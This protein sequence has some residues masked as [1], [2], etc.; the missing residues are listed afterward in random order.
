M[1]EEHSSKMVTEDDE[2]VAVVSSATADDRDFL[3]ATL[4]VRNR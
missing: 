3:G 2:V 1:F 4:F